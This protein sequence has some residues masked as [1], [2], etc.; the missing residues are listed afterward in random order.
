M[1]RLGLAGSSG[2]SSGTTAIEVP[3][4]FEEQ[5]EEAHGVDDEYLAEAMEPDSSSV[6]NPLAAMIVTDS[7]EDVRGA[8]NQPPTQTVAQEKVASIQEGLGSQPRSYTPPILN[9]GYAHG[10]MIRGYQNGS[11]IT[12][13]EEHS[14]ENPEEEIG[15]WKD[16]G[17]EGLKFIFDPTDPWDVA[18]AGLGGAAMFTGG[19][20]AF[21]ASATWLANKARKARK[22]P[23][24]VKGGF[25]LATGRGG[26]PAMNRAAGRVMGAGRKYD[27]RI[28]TLAG[29]GARGSMRNPAIAAAQERAGRKAL[30]IVGPGAAAYGATRF[31]GSLGEGESGGLP[32]PTAAQLAKQG[33]D[34]KAIKARFL[35]I[36]NYKPPV[37][38]AAGVDTADADGEDHP[39]KVMHP[40][41]NFLREAYDRDRI[42][43]EESKK[44]A[45]AMLM[46][47]MASNLS[48]PGATLGSAFDNLAPLVAAQGKER[49]R[50]DE[51]TR[52]VLSEI[53]LAMHRD[54]LNLTDSEQR[55]IIGLINAKSAQRRSIAYKD[56]VEGGGSGGSRASLAVKKE[57]WDRTLD[58]FSGLVP[59]KEDKPE[60][61]KK[62]QES[63][64]FNET[65]LSRNSA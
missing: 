20:S 47:Q 26:S 35:G 29:H 33:E 60:E 37:D 52:N 55:N 15:S 14:L 45:R 10:G 40:Y 3:R 50:S 27:P 56:Y 51:N 6:V 11:L 25:R 16:L 7:R 17:V 8:S 46:L 65:H 58:E 19:L 43:G 54:E 9:R 64:S 32:E 1:A 63:L 57:A 48:K 59:D 24:I 28:E 34:E 41:M 36:I 22:I 4:T 5:L 30:G 61:W 53:S 44:E 49:R 42:Y 12:A 13:E 2:N 38:G 39:R 23:K 21:P 31:L 18:A 62:F